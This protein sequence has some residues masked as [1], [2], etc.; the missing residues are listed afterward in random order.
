MKRNVVETTDL[1]ATST[2]QVLRTSVPNALGASTHHFRLCNGA[3]HRGKH[4][5]FPPLDTRIF[6]LS[7]GGR[8]WAQNIL[9][10]YS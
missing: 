3:Y 9:S 4:L 8:L 10:D 7:E 5:T 1:P 6:L 2:M